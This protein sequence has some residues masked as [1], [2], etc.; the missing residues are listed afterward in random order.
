MN[1][2]LEKADELRDELLKH[3]SVIEYLK[4][5]EV[6]E[7]NKELHGLRKNIASLT[8]E[9]KLEERDNLLAIYN[10]NPLVI[11]YN[12]AREEVMSILNVIKDILK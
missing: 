9:N 5:K 1:K 3:P 11:N 4:L 7:N 12:Q 6:L 8:N 10:N 2:V